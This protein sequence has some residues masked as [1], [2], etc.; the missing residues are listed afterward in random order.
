MTCSDSAE[1]MGRLA[2]AAGAAFLDDAAAPLGLDRTSRGAAAFMGGEG[3]TAPCHLGR[4]G[5]RR[6][7]F[8]S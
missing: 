6:Q 8:I 4:L 1:V 2:H 7:L 3:G 5:P